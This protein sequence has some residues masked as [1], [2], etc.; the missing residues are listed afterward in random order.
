MGSKEDRKLFDVFLVK[1]T[2]GS[3]TCEDVSVRSINFENGFFGP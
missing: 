2:G 1:C 3:L